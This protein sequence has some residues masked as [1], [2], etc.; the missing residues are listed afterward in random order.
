MLTNDLN[1]S[2]GLIRVARA[3]NKQF[4]AFFL[5]FG[6]IQNIELLKHLF[7]SFCSS[8]YGIEILD[9]KKV[10][11]SSSKFWRKSVNL[12]MMKLLRLPRESVSQFLI[13]EG[14]MNA[15]S[16]WSY[17]SLTFWRNV[18]ETV[19][20]NHPLRECNQERVDDIMRKYPG[21]KNFPLA[22]RL[23]IRDV[24]IFDWGLKKE[25]FF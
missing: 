11:V 21:I 4:N 9:P 25:I 20:P 16:I 14:I 19:S 15:D 6:E 17:R 23:Q 22:S 1:D 10:S 8:F 5:R 3:F 12:A 18:F 7:V 24:I 13:A 2:E